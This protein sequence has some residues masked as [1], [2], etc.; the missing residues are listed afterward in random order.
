M[1]IV[2]ADSLPLVTAA[3]LIA[4][5]GSTPLLPNSLALVAAAFPDPHRRTEMTTL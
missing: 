4:G 5:V 3:Q 2:F 1:T